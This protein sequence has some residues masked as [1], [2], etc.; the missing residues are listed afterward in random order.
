MTFVLRGMYGEAHTFYMV[1]SKSNPIFEARQLKSAPGWYVLV[2]W[3]Y[4]QVEQISGFE[5]Q[6]DAQ[7]W[8]TE[9]SEAWLRNRTGAKRDR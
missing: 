7:N 4:G 9:K 6:R 8:S 2:S 5:S 1:E 3:R